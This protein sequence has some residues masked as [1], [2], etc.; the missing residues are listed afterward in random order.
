[1]LCY[2]WIVFS[3]VFLIPISRFSNLSSCGA[4]S[5]H[6][7]RFRTQLL[8]LILVV[9]IIFYLIRCLE[10]F[11]TNKS[12]FPIGSLHPSFFSFFVIDTVFCFFSLWSTK[13][14]CCSS[15]PGP[16]EGTSSGE[17]PQPPRKKRARVDPTVESVCDLSHC[18][19]SLS[20]SFHIAV[21]FFFLS[22]I[23]F[24]H[25]PFVFLSALSQRNCWLKTFLWPQ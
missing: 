12:L 14:T 13:M 11:Y 7:P 16:G 2:L 19:A 10:K 4:D 17:T 8:S 23:H 25:R 21:F 20:Y 9:I 3:F 5:L 15:A 24:P 22:F 1:M 6:C 18:R